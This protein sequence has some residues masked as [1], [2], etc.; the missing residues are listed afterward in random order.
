MARDDQSVSKDAL[1][2]NTSKHD[3]WPLNHAS[4]IFG[5]D[6]INMAEAAHQARREATCCRGATS[7]G[8]QR[9]CKHE[10]RCSVAKHEQTCRP[11]NRASSVG[12]M[13][14]LQA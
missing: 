9:W 12:Y 1:W 8:D 10:Q 6:E 14:L 5:Y 7:W 2:Q 13:K 11:L 3:C 4:R